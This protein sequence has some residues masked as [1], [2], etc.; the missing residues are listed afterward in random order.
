MSLD[1]PKDLAK[2]DITLTAST[3]AEYWDLRYRGFVEQDGAAT[4]SLSYDELTPAQ[5]A[6]RTREQNKAREQHPDVDPDAQAGDA[7]ES[8]DQP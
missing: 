8:T 6:A 1:L 2:G 3:P 5:K 4:A 7:N